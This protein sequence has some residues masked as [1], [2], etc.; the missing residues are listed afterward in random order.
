[1]ETRLDSTR[2]VSPTG[3]VWSPGRRRVTTGLV[4]TVTLI[5]FESLSV[6]TILPVVSRH[7]GDIRLYGWV[8][9]AF[10]LASLLGT[11]AAGSMADRRGARYPMGVG[12][13]VFAAGL[14]IGGAAPDMPVLVA[15]RVVQG[16][17]AGMVPATAYVAIGTSYPA[18]SRPRMFAVLSTAWIVP[19]L[20]GPA[21]AA[22]VATIAGWRWVFIGLIPLVAAAAV[23]ALPAMPLSTSGRDAGPH[24]GRAR[25]L[26]AIGVTSGAGLVLAGL[27]AGRVAISVPL[28]AVGAAVL[29]PA[30]TRLTP[31]GMLRARRGVPAAVL[32]RGLLTFAYFAA[33]AYVP[34]A[35]T[36][37]RHTSTTFA[38]LTLTVAT[39]TWTTGSWVQARL[40]SVR[41]A[42][43]LVSG[44]LVLVVAGI[45][46]MAAVLSRAVPLW[47]APVAWGVSGFGIGVAYSPPSLIVLGFAEPSRVG[48]ASAGLQLSD[49]LGTALGTGISGAAVAI[50]DQRGAG[51][52]AGLLA[53]FTAAAAVALIGLCTSRRLPTQT[54]S[55]LGATDAM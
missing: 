55:H 47:A 27:S 7:L 15:G 6:A 17:G 14:V 24:G 22:Q 29:F 50:A 53:A 51:T 54:T 21:L 19:G 45:A 46:G 33:D 28:V 8:F 43:T 20:I 52:R 3:G 16:L 39:V 5:A 42:R 18:H 49:L 9:S 48:E 40:A 2:S 4:M 13:T 25:L 34:L 30:L 11:V 38:G 31:K 32:V 37:V 44:G 12:L 41:G 35:L 36:S 1:M 23:I 10:F 26:P